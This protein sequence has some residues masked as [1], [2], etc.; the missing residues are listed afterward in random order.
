MTT[1]ES[2]Y[3]RNLGLM[4]TVAA[5]GLAVGNPAARACTNIL[6]T[7]G[8]SVDGSTM[9]SYSADS[10]D[11]YGFLDLRPA[12]EHKPGTMIDVYDW[13][14]G[15][16]RGQIPQAPVTYRV[17][18]NMN[19]FQ[20]SIGETTF[21]QR[22][23][24]EPNEGI[25]DYGS[26]IYIALERSR[27]AREAI[28]VMTSLVE[29][30]GYGSGGESFSIADPD[31]VWFMEIVG[32]GKDAE[33]K[34]IKGALWVARRI[35]DGY[36]AAHANHSRIRQF[37]LDDPENTIYS[38]DVISFARDKGWFCGEDKDFSFSTAYA[39]QDYGALR[40]CE[41]RVWNFFNHVRSSDPIPPDFVKAIPGAE[42]M[43]LWIKPDRKLSVAD[44][45]VEMRDHFEGTEFDLSK[46]IGAGPFGLPY[47]WRPL[48]WEVD[49]K[50]YFNERSIS[51]QQTGFSFVAQMR[52]W[53]PDAVGGVFWFGVDDTSTTVY[54]PM[55]AGIEKAPGPFA[56]DA[57]D[58]TEF[59][60]KSA[61]WV[62]SAVS[63]KT[64][65]RWVDVIKDV[66]VRQKSLEDSF[67]SMLPG[68]EALAVQLHALSPELARGFLTQ[69]SA[70]A[71][72]NA[73]EQW[74][75]LWREIFV[76]Y[77]DGNVR[78]DKGVAQHPPLPENWYR[79]IISENPSAF[80]LRDVPQP[81]STCK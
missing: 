27:T 45:K 23:E 1:V 51:T 24:L 67:D 63:E 69:V 70:A 80:E 60:W 38:P 78:D 11:L 35:P 22:E 65:S 62:F 33:G 36:V 19:E 14:E 18:G 20:V 39:L 59:S 32:K 3:L 16:L 42:P 44:V 30:Y 43:P 77:N 37:P 79:A 5:L 9:I 71:G 29:E 58:F 6:V 17:V 28:T 54:V 72:N 66:R 75:S 4:M 57:G 25:I 68:V 15:H 47:R 41:S 34:Q 61:F 49:G 50:K 40:F 64:Y 76:K 55:F 56:K 52:S 12:G 26:L 53:L 81:P 13:D 10:H 7:R 31:E 21:T 73:Y 8:A 46:G 2:R 48:E 74:I